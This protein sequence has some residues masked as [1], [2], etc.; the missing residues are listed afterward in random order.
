MSKVVDPTIDFFETPEWVVQAIV[1]KLIWGDSEQW[2]LDPCVLDP[3]AGRGAILRAMFLCG[4]GPLRLQG[5]E[6][7]AEF[8]MRASQWCEPRS[9]TVSDA[10]E[11]P[12]SWPK[13]DK[14]VMNPPFS[15][16]IEFVRAALSTNTDE[17]AVLGRLSMLES[18]GRAEFWW[19][20]PCDVYV[21][22]DRPAFTRF[23]G[24]KEVSAGTDRWAYAWFVWRKFRPGH[25]EI[26]NCAKK[27][28]R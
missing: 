25:W 6:L 10:L 18:K 20:N 4:Y 26:L 21:L 28:T 15:K 11:C 24:G 7:N 17:V 2:V 19:A 12:T 14:I 1:P 22:S 27:E 3:C 23:V 5:I 9:V 8:A 16:W 13:A